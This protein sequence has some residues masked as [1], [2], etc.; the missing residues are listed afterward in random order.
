MTDNTTQSEL[1]AKRVRE[2]RLTRHLTLVEAANEI[3]DC[4]YPISM[5]T[6]HYIETGQRKSL[7]FDFVVAAAAFFTPG[8]G[9]PNIPAFLYGP[10]C[11]DCQDQPPSKFICRTCRRSWNDEGTEL[12]PC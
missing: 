6:L 8:Y 2:L 1:A 9:A 12:I 4:G 7:P 3:T 10:L 11:S 5:G